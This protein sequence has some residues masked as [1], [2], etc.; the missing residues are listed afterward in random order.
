MLNKRVAKV[1]LRH[2]LHRLTAE[3]G[4][5]DWGEDA[6]IPLI[7]SGYGG[8]KL[9]CLFGMGILPHAPLTLHQHLKQATAIY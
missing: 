8:K 3:S 5:G 9:K 1:A 6:S 4:A 7:H 2:L